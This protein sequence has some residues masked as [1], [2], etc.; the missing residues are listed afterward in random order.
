MSVPP[1][2]IGLC[3]N[4]TFI[5]SKD[6]NFLPPSWPPP[7]DFPVVIDAKGEVITRYDDPIWV[8]TP[9]AG[10]A[11]KLNFGDGPPRGKAARIS[12][13][14]AAVFRRV[15]AWWLWG[16]NAV[17]RPRTLKQ[18]HENLRSLFV[19][20]S[21]EKIVATDL[22]RHPKV[23]ERLAAVI[24]PSAGAEVVR[25]LHDLWEQ[26]DAVG[27][28]I[29]DA[30]GIRALAASIS[31]RCSAQTPYIPPRIWLYQVNR[32][33][34]FLDDFLSH[35]Q[36]IEDCYH[37]CLDAYA[38]NAGSLALA[39]EV[40]VRHREPFKA[41][42]AGISGAR[43]GCKFHG[44]FAQTAKR[45]GID[46]VIDRWTGPKGSSIFDTYASIQAFSSYFT[47]VG[48]VGTA[49][50]LNFSMMR[51]EEGWS[52]RSDCLTVE[53]DVVD[54]D[55]F[56]LCG[57]TSKTTDDDDARWIASPSVSA[58]VEA[59]SVVSRL[60]MIAAEAHSKIPTT[61]E[62]LCNPFLVLRPYE[63]WSGNSGDIYQPLAVRPVPQSLDNVV[64][65]NPKLFDTNQMRITQAD[66]DAALLITPT[67]DPKRFAVGK[68]WPLSWH[69]LR[70]TGAVNMNA[71]G[72]VGEAS[73]QYQLKHVTRAMSRYYGQGYYHLQ[74]R[75]NDKTRTEYVRVMYEV[76]AREFAQ[77]G[78]N[79][80]VSPY[81]DQRKAQIVKLVGEKDH[82]GLVANAK[83]GKLAYREHLLGGCTNPAPCDKGGIDS[84][85]PC[86]GNGKP[87]EHLLY[88]RKKIPSYQRI[89]RVIASRLAEADGGSPLHESL[90][91][92]QRGVED[93]LNACASL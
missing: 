53:R 81:G 29:L 90:K 10:M 34:A 15:T 80:F 78:S 64:Q 8:L 16:Q 20:C 1:E 84:V 43:T 25:S 22:M 3:I 59:M 24:S 41:A 66:L 51:I 68:V 82:K 75:L 72:V 44:T 67:L 52:L 69:Q 45:F 36:Q 55:I 49:Y 28:V 65:L 89:G 23:V 40:G 91:V 79:R 54:E 6:E 76:I 38:R 85:A 26:R 21:A 60:R 2:L 70:R 37:F 87:C 63:P 9:W 32:L 42:Y 62:D 13:A 48:K 92:Q 14:N 86:G 50:L 61:T 71:S 30:N 35:R 74:L 39:C 18:K 57:P 17:Q 4:S 56:V 77:L 88:D 5:S 46:H 33:R 83:E 47:L 11:H 93:A 73:V 12:P 7:P 19:L 31:R 27:L 58:A